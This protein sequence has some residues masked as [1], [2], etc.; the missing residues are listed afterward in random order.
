MLVAS[1]C[2]RYL[3]ALVATAGNACAPV[4]AGTLGPTCPLTVFTV[5]ISIRWTPSAQNL[6]DAP[7]RGSTDV[8]FDEAVERRLQSASSWAS[9]LKNS[10][11]WRR[12]GVLPFPPSNKTAS[13]AHSWDPLFR[14]KQH[15]QTWSPATWRSWYQKDILRRHTGLG[16]KEPCGFGLGAGG[17]ETAKAKWSLNRSGKTNYPSRG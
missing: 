16:S 17:S 13:A 1:A 6:A 7:S 9:T 8:R 5:R 15:R 12:A 10:V 14:S 4:V 3:S 11:I 2:Q